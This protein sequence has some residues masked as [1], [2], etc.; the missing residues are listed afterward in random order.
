MSFFSLLLH[1]IHRAMDEY[2]RGFEALKVMRTL[3]WKPHLGL[4]DL[5]VE[6][7]DRTLSLSVSPAQATAIMHFQDKGIMSQDADHP[8]INGCYYKLHSKVLHITLFFQIGGP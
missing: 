6:L 5:D 1:V 2:T 7:A 8:V 4:V 3:Q